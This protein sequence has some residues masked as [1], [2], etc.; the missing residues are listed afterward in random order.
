[1]GMII[2]CF[3]GGGGASTGIEMALGR[4]VD[5]AINHDPE[6]IRMHSVNHPSALHLTEDIFKVDLQKYTKGKE[7]DL[8]WASPTCTHF[9]KAKG[10]APKSNALRMLPWSVF[11]HAQ[12]IKPSVI[13]MENVSEIQMWGPLDDNGYPI[14]ALAGTE[15]NRFMNAMKSLGY[16]YEARELNSAD[17][18]A[19]TARNRWYAILRCDDKDIVWPEPTHSK[20]GA[21]GLQK[22]R[23][24]GDFIDFSN[25]GESIYHRDKP[26]AESTERRIR[27][28]F[29]KYITENEHPYIVDRPEA[30]EYLKKYYADAEDGI[31]VSFLTKFY[32]SDCGQMLD[33][34]LG[35]ITCSMGHFALVTAF[36]VKY[37]GNSSAQSL[38]EPLGT[39]TCKDRFGLVSVITEINGE[40][41]V[42]KDAFLR[43]LTPNE[44]KTLQGF[45]DDYIID[46][47]LNFKVYPKKEQVARIG[48]SVVPLMAEKIIEANCGYLKV[49]ERLPNLQMYEAGGGQIKFA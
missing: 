28:G 25:L 19:L 35:T 11:Q 43:M 13:V 48:N 7:V 18:G 41:Y 20:T 15:Y 44:Y 24:C 31:M 14:K 49:G 36:L 29:R 45:P 6:A 42:M 39:I 32:K 9:S 3:A 38:S 1:M 12:K 40:K 26:L 23:S 47:D 22:W 4:S 8:M 46:R 27:E 34:P 30:Y 17:Y 10:A 37:Y 2:D 5:I 33:R 21:N 16:R